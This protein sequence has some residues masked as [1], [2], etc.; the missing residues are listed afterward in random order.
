MKLINLLL[1]GLVLVFSACQSE[2]SI[3]DVYKDE[4][5]KDLVSKHLTQVTKDVTTADLNNI[6][7]TLFDYKKQSRSS[8]AEISIIKDGEGIDRIIC[9]NFCND[10]GFVLISAQKS[11][12]PV[13][14][15]SDFGHFNVNTEEIP[16]PLNIW[17]GD[18]INEIASSENLPM[19][20]I[21]SVHSVWRRYE[22][23]IST[24][25]VED[26]LS[27][28]NDLINMT[29]DEYMLLSHIMMGKINQWN[30]MGYRVYAI[31]DYPGTTSLGDRYGMGSFVQS[32]INP[33]Y[34]DD[35]WAITLVVEKDIDNSYT[36]ARKIKT[37]W[38]QENGFNQSL[39]VYWNSYEGVSKNI[40]VGCG[41]LS[42][43]QIMYANRYPETFDWDAMSV[44]GPGN[45]ITADFLR[46]LYEQCNTVFL[47]ESYSKPPIYGSSSTFV[48]RMKALRYYGY[49]YDSIPGHQI[50]HNT[51]MTK[52]PLMVS[53]YFDKDVVNKG[54]AW[55]I[56]G[57]KH[58]EYR[59][60][61]ELWTFD[62]SNDF[63]CIF[64]EKS[65]SVNE[66][67][68]YAVWGFDDDSD[69][70]YDLTKM[71]P[72][73]QSYYSNIFKEAAG[74]IKPKNK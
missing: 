25:I 51:I 26:Y 3:T 62:Y 23:S 12:I 13:L 36:K 42:L 9:V 7:N 32:C 64:S 5:E 17:I 28:N 33:Y 20:S 39:G 59:N 18:K 8:E 4:V 41:P 61:T 63:V 47:D 72:S 46:E 6:L 56:D 21:A 58:V 10:N 50:D 11:H 71:L 65:N 15:Y 54:H 57:G 68:Y 1:A 22:T 37:K 52:S 45:K 74:N 30:A 34:M 35:Y 2:D 60:E 73:G 55:I 40:P 70:Y 67:K 16:F 19:D 24:P 43:G 38:T 49:S 66:N 53:S 27:D 69:G 48:D 44:S 29:W 31:N 14:A